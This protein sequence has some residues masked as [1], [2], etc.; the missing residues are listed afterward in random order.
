[1]F[2]GGKLP[3]KS[4]KNQRGIFISREDAAVLLTGHCRHP[5][6][7]FSAAKKHPKKRTFMSTGR[8]LSKR[9]V[10]YI[11]GITRP[12]CKFFWGICSPDIALTYHLPAFDPVPKKQTIQPP[13]EKIQQARRHV[14]FGEA[15]TR[16]GLRDQYDPSQD[17]MHAQ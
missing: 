8:T 11:F 6:K 9:G 10:Y 3:L 17:S 2:S 13:Y 14:G 15:C 1:M 4:S 7:R 16:H 12:S 5:Q